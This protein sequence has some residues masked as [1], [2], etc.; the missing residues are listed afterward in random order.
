MLGHD[1]M[2]VRLD[3]EVKVALLVRRRCRRVR[4]DDDLATAVLVLTSDWR[5]DQ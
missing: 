2:L 3:N 5:P 4:A 1:S